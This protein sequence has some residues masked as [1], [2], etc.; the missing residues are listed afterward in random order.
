M[1]GKSCI[2]PYVMENGWSC[3][4]SNVSSWCVFYLNCDKRKQSSSYQVYIELCYF[5]V[6]VLLFFYKLEYYLLY[7]IVLE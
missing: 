6:L 4:D 3:I 2:Y 7:V 1:I 5:Y